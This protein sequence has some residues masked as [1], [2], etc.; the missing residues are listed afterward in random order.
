MNSADD[1]TEQMKAREQALDEMIS[2]LSERVSSLLFRVPALLFNFII[3]D[4][5]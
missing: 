1:K 4:I 5:P 2:V 3:H